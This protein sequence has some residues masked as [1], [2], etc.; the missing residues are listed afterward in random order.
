M[1]DR[2]PRLKPPHIEALPLPHIARS[3]AF[4][5]FG[6]AGFMFLLLA[7]MTALNG[8]LFH[9]LVTAAW[10]TLFSGIPA[11]IGF[12]DWHQYHLALELEKDGLSS[13][14]TV[15][16]FYDE[17]TS[18]GDLSS[19]HIHWVI[20]KLDDGV[21]VRQVVR[22]QIYA[23]LPAGARIEVL[24]LPR[25]HRICRAKFPASLEQPSP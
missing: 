22:P 25:D 6:T 19:T 11:G 5:W 14:A 10:L 20:F 12:H 7:V 3:G 15:A 23:S 21:L 2:Q 17:D 18:L 24:L 8:A 9:W 16:G 13:F 4:F 1:P